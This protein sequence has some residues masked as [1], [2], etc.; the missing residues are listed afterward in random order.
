MDTFVN[1]I[2]GIWV[3]VISFCLAA[4]LDLDDRT[5]QWRQRKFKEIERN[6]H[7]HRRN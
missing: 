1:I 5:E 7:G 6:R 2:L 4:Q 3:F